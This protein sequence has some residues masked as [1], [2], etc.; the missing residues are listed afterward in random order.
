MRL[1]LFAVAV[2]SIVAF[3]VVDGAASYYKRR[4]GA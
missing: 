3:A 4:F 1:V 2:I